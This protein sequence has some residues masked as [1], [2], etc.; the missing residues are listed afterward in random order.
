MLDPSSTLKWLRPAHTNSHMS[1]D[2]IVLSDDDEQLVASP[3]AIQ[4]HD[5]KPSAK[6]RKKTDTHG[7]KYIMRGL[8][9]VSLLVRRA[10]TSSDVATAGE[11]KRGVLEVP[12][13]PRRRRRAMLDCAYAERVL[14]R[15][16]HT[17]TAHAAHA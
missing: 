1:R 9:E 15:G 4:V 8:H 6:K 11:E 12:R 13:R 3:P 14:L 2:V 10:H 7:I 16:D 5:E 17:A